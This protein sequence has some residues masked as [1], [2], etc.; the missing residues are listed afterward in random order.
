AAKKNRRRW[1]CPCPRRRS[2]R[3]FS[4]AKLRHQ[5]GA[6]EAH[7]I[8]GRVRIGEQEWI[9]IGVNR[10][11]VHEIG[12]CLDDVGLSGCAGKTE[13]E[14]AVGAHESAGYLR[15]SRGSNIDGNGGNLVIRIEIGSVRTCLRRVNDGSS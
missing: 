15:R 6:V 5:Q 13:L 7:W 10:N 3:R 14:R 12:G 4:L 8:I 2:D 11:P 1:I 9:H